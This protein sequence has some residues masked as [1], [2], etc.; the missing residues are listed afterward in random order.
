MSEKLIIR[1]F[2]PIKDVELELKSLNVFIGDQGTGKSTIAKLYSA[3]KLFTN[4]RFLNLED[5]NLEND[6]NWQFQQYV[7]QLELKNYFNTDTSFY[8]YDPRLKIEVI[9]EGN[10]ISRNANNYSLSIPGFTYIVA[11]RVYVSILSDALYGLIE[12]G[13]KLPTL[14]NRFGNKFSSS[15]KEAS[16]A[17]YTDIIG[18]DFSHSNGI[19]NILLKNGKILPLSD[20]S[21]GIQGAIPLLVVFDSVVDRIF[22]DSNRQIN[23]QNL[24]VIEEP[25]LNLFP[26]T[27]QKLLNYLVENNFEFVNKDLK[28]GEFKNQLI[29]TT[30]S[31]YILTSLNNLMFAYEA[32]KSNKEGVAKIIE[33]KCWLNPDDVSVY[34]LL[35]DGTCEN[36][37][38]S[39]LKQIKVEKIDEISEVLSKQWHQLADLNFVAK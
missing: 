35:V 38:D 10:L 22:S 14:F 8:Y 13:A 27:Q 11:E 21:S 18:V 20:G 34:R 2:G 19:D 5:S 26:Y 37:M 39:E 1:N 12:T 3:I 17:Y 24:L 16:R 25:E 15:R 6:D 33:E 28:N 29:L 7:N 23:K 31:P 36:I 30:H 32:G 4:V 9:Y